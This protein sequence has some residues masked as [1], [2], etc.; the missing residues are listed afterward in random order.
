MRWLVRYLALVAGLIC[1]AA[2]AAHEISIPIDLS[3][4]NTFELLQPLR[5]DCSSQRG[6]QTPQGE[7]PNNDDKRAQESLCLRRAL[8]AS[9]ELERVIRTYFPTDLTPAE[10]AF[11]VDEV[12]DAEPLF[13]CAIFWVRNAVAEQPESPGALRKVYRQQKAR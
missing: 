7:D 4:P 13:R 5:R 1:L 3:D 8:L 11:C 2:A 10:L 6:G 12:E 9:A